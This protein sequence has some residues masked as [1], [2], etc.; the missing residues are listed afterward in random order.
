MLVTWYF[1]SWALIFAHPCWSSSSSHFFVLLTKS[2]CSHWSFCC[3]LLF[4]AFPT[5][6]WVCRRISSPLRRRIHS[7]FQW[8]LIKYPRQGAQTPV[9]GVSSWLCSLCWQIPEEQGLSWGRGVSLCPWAGWADGVARPE[10]SAETEIGQSSQGHAA[11][12]QGWR[13][14]EI[15]LPIA[16]WRLVWAGGS[17]S[18]A[19]T[20]GGFSKWQ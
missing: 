18:A 5:C 19:E 20:P 7:M 17:L 9:L 15:Q 11:L 16:G 13:L 1:L 12:P 8:V 14:R 4:P 6:T 2:P 3:S 10:G